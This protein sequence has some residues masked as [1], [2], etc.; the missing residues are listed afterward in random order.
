[1]NVVSSQNVPVMA[2]EKGSPFP[3]PYVPAP[4]QYP[5]VAIL[6]R[7]WLYRRFFMY[8]VLTTPARPDA[9]TRYWNRIVPEPPPSLRAH[10]AE[11]GRSE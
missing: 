1:M 8:L 4:F 9:S 3:G 7:P 2:S 6:F 10:V 11:T 5:H